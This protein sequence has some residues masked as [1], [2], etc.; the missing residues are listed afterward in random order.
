GV[1]G[2]GRV[3][4]SM[5]PGAGNE[6]WRKAGIGGGVV[7]AKRQEPFERQHLRIAESRQPLDVKH[8]DLVYMRAALAHLKV[9]VELLIV[10]DEQDARAAVVENVLDLLG[11]VCGVNAI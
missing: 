4:R 10:L 7:A 2:E 1:G 3:G 5:G 9:L 11:S 8:D 6:V